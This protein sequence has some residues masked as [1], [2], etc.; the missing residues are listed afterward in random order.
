MAFRVTA[1]L[2]EKGEKQMKRLVGIQEMADAIGIPKSQCYRMVARGEIPHYRAGKYIKLDP[3]E[4]LLALHKD[5]GN[6]P[7]A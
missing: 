4:V 2:P 6:G 3:D 5:T 1:R 7:E